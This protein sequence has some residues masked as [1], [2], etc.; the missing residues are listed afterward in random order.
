[1]AAWTRLLRLFTASAPTASIE[2]AA[3]R[4]TGV[5][6]G[7]GPNQEAIAVVTESLPEGVLIPTANAPNVVDRG[8]LGDVA[9]QVLRQLPG[10]P[11]RV[12]LVVPDCAAKVSLMTFE[13]TPARKA[14][15]DELVR[16]QARKTA[17]FRIE[18]AQVAY[19]AGPPTDGGGREFVVSLMRRDIVE[20]YETACARAGAHAGVVDLSSF[21]L[22]N[23]V[24]ARGATDGSDWLLVHVA[25]G[26][27]SIAVVRQGQPILFRNRPSDDSDGDDH[28]VDLVHQTTMYYE[29]RLQ[30]A[31][32]GRAFLAAS[33]RHLTAT[34]A[35]ALR[36]S[37]E[38]RIGTLVEG[39]DVGA[40]AEQTGAG[41]P[42]LDLIAAP[43]G[44][45]LRERKPI[46][47]AA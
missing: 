15:L 3:D 31:G 35:D 12:A 14:D 11:T 19:A 41:G 6:L 34:D 20:E 1:M 18:D 45:L 17:P 36:H 26:Y 32:F 8:T 7:P 21:C 22:V 33:A 44:V 40:P 9:R 46:S 29:D 23:A 10:P 27:S 28:L 37:L 4:I 30:G 13:Q 2:I 5:V 25:P 42:L 38:S 43:L 39:I 47:T 16:W 24:L